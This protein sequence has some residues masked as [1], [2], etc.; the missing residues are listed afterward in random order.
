MMVTFSANLAYTTESLITFYKEINKYNHFL[1]DFMWNF[2]MD[3]MFEWSVY[4]VTDIEFHHNAV[5]NTVLIPEYSIKMIIDP[6]VHNNFR[7]KVVLPHMHY[8]QSFVVFCRNGN[9]SATIY[10]GRTC[11]VLTPNPSNRVPYKHVY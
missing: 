6:L 7:F 1:N 4:T 3:G 2:I 9:I 11:K 5:P 10:F 8:Q